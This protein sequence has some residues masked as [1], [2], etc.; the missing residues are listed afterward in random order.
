MNIEF[1]CEHCKNR[2]DVPLSRCSYDVRISELIVECV[3]AKCPLC[4]HF[5]HAK[6]HK[7]DEIE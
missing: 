6:D 5:C 4:G 2:F 1:V 3:I 7:V